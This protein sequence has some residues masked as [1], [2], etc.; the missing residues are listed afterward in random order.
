[1]RKLFLGDKSFDLA[2]TVDVETLESE[3]SDAL[4][5]EKHV[6]VDVVVDHADVSLTV[7]PR[8][9]PY[10]YV[11]DKPRQAPVRVY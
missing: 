4:V 8:I 7:N 6:R 10:W 2:E 1:M 11:L 9:V 3:L 5:G